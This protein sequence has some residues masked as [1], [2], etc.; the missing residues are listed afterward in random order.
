MIRVLLVD[1]EHLMRAGLRMMLETQPDL[2]VVGEAADGAEAVRLAAATSP[3]VILMDVRMPGMDGVDATRAVVA[4]GS[5]AAVLVLTTF[6]LDEYVFAAIRAGAAGF[7]LKRTPPEQLLAG[8][9]TLAAGEAIL[10]PSVTKRLLAEFAR[11]APPKPPEQVRRSLARL[12]AREHE[13]LLLLGRG[14]SNAEISARL[15]IGETTT[16]THVKRILDKLGLRDR[17][18]AAVFAFDH[19]LVRAGAG[20]LRTAGG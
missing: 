5:S 7:L 12:T 3:D 8:I 6:E 1:D 10:G 4:S 20:Q 18:H 14:M 2:Q 19:G 15:H 13:V 11:A 16:K 17:V 9:R